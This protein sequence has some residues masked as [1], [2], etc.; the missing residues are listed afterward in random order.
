MKI[1][2]TLLIFFFIS[3]I[4]IHSCN[5]QLFSYLDKKENSNSNQKENP[6]KKITTPIKPIQKQVNQNH[7]PYRVENKMQ[8]LPEA[9]TLRKIHAVKKDESKIKS[10]VSQ[11]L[12]KVNKLET[13]IQK[14][15]QRNTYLESTIRNNN[16]NEVSLLQK[17]QK[18]VSNIKEAVKSEENQV[19]KEVK[20]NLSDNHMEHAKIIKENEKLKKE[21][22]RL[23]EGMHMVFII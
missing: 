3:I 10:K 6:I 8:T 15:R 9:L 20:E 5:K 18:Q 12:S 21:I 4:A 17:Y 23:E 16:H 19:K 1:N 22:T 2:Q 11:A 13:E 14:L 7:K